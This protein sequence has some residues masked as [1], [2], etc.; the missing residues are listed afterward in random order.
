MRYSFVICNGLS[1][2]SRR[3]ETS[4]K[5]SCKKLEWFKRYGSRERKKCNSEKNDKEVEKSKIQSK[6][7]V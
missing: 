2:S 6:T 4:L 1:H 3:D 5:I 7:Y